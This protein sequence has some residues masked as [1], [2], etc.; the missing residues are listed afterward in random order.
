[1]V[2]GA[3]VQSTRENFA[4][5]TTPTN[6]LREHNDIELSTE[7]KSDNLA[8]R[9]CLTFA[10]SSLAITNVDGYLN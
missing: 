10:M 2:G 7:V 4:P 9:H 5:E 3:Q 6:T 8:L 1:M